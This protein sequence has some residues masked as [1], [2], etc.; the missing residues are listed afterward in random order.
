MEKDPWWSAHQDTWYDF[1]A[2]LWDACPV[3]SD[4]FCPTTKILVI[5]SLLLPYHLLFKGM[6]S[7]GGWG[8]GGGANN[9]FRFLFNSCSVASSCLEVPFLVQMLFSISL[10]V[11]LETNVN[12]IM[13]E[14][15]ERKKKKQQ[16]FGISESRWANLLGYCDCCLLLLDA[17]FKDSRTLNS[18]RFTMHVTV[19]LMTRRTPSPT[20]MGDGGIKYVGSRSRFD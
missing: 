14:K 7:G 6:A 16:H 12:M 15:K 3:S 13:R 8:W 2:F 1:A 5:K 4:E 20:P 18:L 10:S 11:I 19:S 17:V 9:T